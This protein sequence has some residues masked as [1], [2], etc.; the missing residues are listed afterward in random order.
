VEVGDVGDAHAGLVIRGLVP[1]D[2]RRVLEAAA[3]QRARVELLPREGAWRV[4]EV[5]RVERGG[6]IVRIH[7]P[8]PDTGR[9]IRCWLR[10]DGAAYTFDASV[11]RVGVSVPDRSQSGVLLGFVDHWQAAPEGRH[12]M[13]LE[14]VPA[15]GRP[16]SLI[17]GAVRLVELGPAEWTVAAPADFGLVFV[18][19]GSVRLRIGTPDRPPVEVHARVQRLARGDGHLLYGLHVEE[20]EAGERYQE[21][22]EAIRASLGL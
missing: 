11:L 22:V 2:P 18:E 12:H 4:G 17:D 6:V 5:V 7:G 13:V 15:N 16:V 1:S 3:D 10:V 9:D 8:V 21:L 20:V 14:V 19:Q